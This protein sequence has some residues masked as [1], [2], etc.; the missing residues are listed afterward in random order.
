MKILT[1]KDGSFNALKRS[2]LVRELL[3][4]STKLADKLLA[5]P[6]IFAASGLGLFS[7]HA[8]TH[9]QPAPGA[10]MTRWAAEVN[11]TNALPE[12]PRPQLVRHDWLN[13]NGL[14]DYQIT[15]AATPPTTNFTGQILVPFPNELFRGTMRLAER[16]LQ[17]TR[18]A[19]RI[20]AKG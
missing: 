18:Y 11:P 4:W 3:G 7:A 10:L 12:Y 13:L 2:Q 16:L 1:N 5:L 8:Q 20:L 14:W 15:P 9:W 19:L 6:I 17:D